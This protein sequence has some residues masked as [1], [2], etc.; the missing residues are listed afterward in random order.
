[1]SGWFNKTRFG[2]EIGVLPPVHETW[3]RVA[4]LP[5]RVC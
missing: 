4:A 2:E 5:A 1:M 3:S